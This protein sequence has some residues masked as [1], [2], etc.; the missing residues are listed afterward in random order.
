MK[1]IKI[2]VVVQ[3]K[4]ENVPDDKYYTIDGKQLPSAPRHGVYINNKKKYFK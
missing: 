3:S 1:T 4:K 2:K